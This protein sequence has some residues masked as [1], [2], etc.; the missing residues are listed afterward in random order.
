ML[1]QVPAV[2]APEV[3]RAEPMVRL[4]L[5]IEHSEAESMTRGSPLFAKV[6]RIEDRLPIQSEHV[7]DVLHEI[8]DRFAVLG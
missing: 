4:S 1:D 7:L 3:M 6:G 5:W 8:E 2:D